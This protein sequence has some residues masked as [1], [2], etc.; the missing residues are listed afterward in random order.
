MNEFFT[1]KIILLLIYLTIY[2]LS[3][4]NSNEHSK[5]KIFTVNRK[6]LTTFL[7]N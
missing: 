4:K 5:K 3:L 1:L 2:I 7:I 6:L